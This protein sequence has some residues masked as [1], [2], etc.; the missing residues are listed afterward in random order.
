MSGEPPLASEGPDPR[1]PRVD[2]PCPYPE[3]C[4]V[5]PRPEVAPRPRL[6]AL[7]LEEGTDKGPWSDA[8]GLG[9][10]YTRHYE[11]EFAPFRDERGV[12]LEIGVLYGASLRCW[13]KWFGK[14][15]RIVG[16][17][18]NLFPQTTLPRDGR[19]HF[20]LCNVRDHDRLLE[21]AMRHGG[22]VKPAGISIVVDDGS[23]VPSDQERAFETLWPFVLPGGLY[24]IED[25]H[26]SF[27]PEDVYP[28][29]VFPFLHETID[30]CVGRGKWAKWSGWDIGD[31]AGRE[32]EV[33]SVRFYRNMVVIEKALGPDP[34]L[35]FIG[36]ERK[37]PQ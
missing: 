30:S 17:D 29:T 20:E 14:K 13:S 37:K 9:H 2:G 4:S 21:V 35:T 19:T 3:P 8:K 36:K 34:Q 31:P 12:F 11:R 23:H 18:V 24:V 15:M 1:R 33:A 22:M 6:D 26:S 16:V 5:H 25:L 10:G 7:A 28:G 27:F 32:L